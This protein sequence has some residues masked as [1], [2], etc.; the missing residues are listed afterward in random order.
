MT[1]HSEDHALR[2]AMLDPEWAR[3]HELLTM[4]EAARTGDT[5]PEDFAQRFDAL[6]DAVMQGR[7]A[8]AWAGLARHLAEDALATLTRLDLD[9]MI[10]ALAPMAAPALGPRL[11][12]LQPQLASPWPGVALV[13]ELLMLGTGAEVGLM[14][15][16]LHA[17]A[18]AV[19]LG[20]LKIEG[21]SP[22]PQLRP[23]P[24]LI[25]ALLHRDTELAPPPGAHLV[26]RIG[27]W[28]DLVLPDTTLRRLHDFAAWVHRAQ[29]LVTDWQARPIH[30][31][32]ALFSGGSGTGKSFAA[33]VIVHELARRTGS[34]WALYALDL[35][36]I[37]S[38]YVGETEAN[39]NA[40]LDSLEGRNAVLQI[41]EADGLLGKRGEVSDA[42]DRYA[43]LEVSHMLARFERHAGP[44][45]LTT[46]LRSNVDTAFLR[47]FQLIVDF[48]APDAEARARLW[49][50][51]LPRN[52]PIAP[53][54]NLPALG[55]AVRLSGGSI[56]NA[57]DYAAVLAAEAGS[58][59]DLPHLARAVWAELTKDTRQVRKSE[60]GLLAE[61][62]E[63]AP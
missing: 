55:Q 50:V 23:G 53:R 9:L 16:R 49:Q 20:L 21:I 34:P 7:E 62:L 13:Q 2:Q 1:L 10:L 30:G 19:R 57:A 54:V 42:R 47:R 44:V 43:N 61:Y 37:M 14:F 8:G 63:E 22:N 27:Q 6:N 4:A 25:R 46:N 58:P 5:L 24:A 11:Q 3:V 41:D 26:E 12:S 52:A 15:D 59:I 32:L 17:T 60:I 18:P 35:G 56:R 28:S 31:P 36:R 39:L 33:S 29:M 48:P 38:K 45:I 51:L 40:L